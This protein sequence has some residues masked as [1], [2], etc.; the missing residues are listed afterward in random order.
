MI[1]SVAACSVL[2]GVRTRTMGHT[3]RDILMIERAVD[4]RLRE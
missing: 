3:T 4:L 2:G 1:N